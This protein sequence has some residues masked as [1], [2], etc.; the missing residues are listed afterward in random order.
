MEVC[1]SFTGLKSLVG[2]T[3]D[4]EGMERTISLTDTSVKSEAYKQ[5][6]DHRRKSIKKKKI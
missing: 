3:E 5:G 6:R 2:D 1:I 4:T